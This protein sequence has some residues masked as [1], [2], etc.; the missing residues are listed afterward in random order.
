MKIIKALLRQLL[1]LTLVA[2]FPA[3]WML[4]SNMLNQTKMASVTAITSSNLNHQ[5][6]IMRLKAKHKKEI[7][8]LKLKNK[9]NIAKVKMKERSKRLVASVPLVGTVL[10]LWAG[11]DEYEDYQE[12]LKDTPSGTAEEYATY[13]SNLLVE[14]QLH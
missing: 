8:Q 14:P 9:K 11:K 10:L 3:S 4:F 1:I 5:K 7:A 12:W 6:D 2:G 13:K